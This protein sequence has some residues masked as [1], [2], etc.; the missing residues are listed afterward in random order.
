[1]HVSAAGLRVEV[2]GTPFP[3]HAE[4]IGWPDAKHEQLMR[5]TTL[6]KVLRLELDPRQVSRAARWALLTNARLLAVLL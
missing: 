3:R 1:M 4:I 5:A 6:A 2:N